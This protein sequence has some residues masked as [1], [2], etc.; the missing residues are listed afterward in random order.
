MKRNQLNDMKIHPQFGVSLRSK[1]C[2]VGER[3]RK[4]AIPKMLTFRL[5]VYLSAVFNRWQ[6][7]FIGSPHR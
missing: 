3:Q 6:R 2:V 5:L 4:K 1:M 7:H